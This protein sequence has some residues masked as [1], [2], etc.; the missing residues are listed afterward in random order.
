LKS[1]TDESAE[2]ED[3]ICLK[4]GAKDVVEIAADLV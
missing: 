2:D 4:P 3:D 1:A